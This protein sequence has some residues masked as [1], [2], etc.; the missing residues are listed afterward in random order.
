MTVATMKMK[1]SDYL[2]EADDRKIKAL[3][4]LLENDI[5]DTTISRFTPEQ[6]QLLEHE[7]HMHVNGETSSYS[8]D[9]AKDLIRAAKNR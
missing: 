5:Q 6:L 9:E 7:H 3:Y 2:A 8:W 1:L 4:T